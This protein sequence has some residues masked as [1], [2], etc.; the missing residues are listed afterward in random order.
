MNRGSIHGV[1][2]ALRVPGIFNLS[3]ANDVLLCCRAKLAKIEALMCYV[4]LYCSWFGQSISVE[5]SGFFMSKG[6]PRQ[7]LH[8]VRTRW[9]FSKLSKGTKYLRVP[10]FFSCNKSKD[11]GYAKERIKARISGWKSK[12]LSWIGRA[13]LIKSVALST[14]IYA[15][16]TLKFPKKLNE[17][18]DALIR[19]FWWSPKHDGNWFFTP[20]AW[21]NLCKPLSEGG[22]G[23]K[24]FE[25]LNEAMITK[26]AWWV[27]S[28]R[29]S[30]CVKV[31]RAKYHVESQW[32]SSRPARA[33]SFSWRGVKSVKHILSKGACK[34]VSLGVN[35]LV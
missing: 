31:L 19:K 2:L 14:L 27:L 8:Q 18:M 21:S 20:L 33:A 5:K 3:Y 15:M 17:E 26:L 32:L 9:S 12:S 11:L 6:V 10:L 23:F 13:T 34:I 1:S 25:C 28:G 4:N 22:L 16:S 29:D 35:I 7:F 24:S 30:F